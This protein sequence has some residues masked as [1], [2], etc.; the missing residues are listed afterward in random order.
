MHLKGLLTIINKG[1]QSIAEY[2]QHAKSIAD[3]LAML[4]LQKTLKI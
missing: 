3:E 4:V 2:M 1:T